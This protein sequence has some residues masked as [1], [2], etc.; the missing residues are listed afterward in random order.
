MSFET[1]SRLVVIPGDP[2]VSYEAAGYGSWLEAYYNPQAMFREVLALSVMEKG[3]RKAHGMTILGVKKQEFGSVLRDLNPTAVRAYGAHWPADLACRHKMPS[4]PVVVSVHDTN[5]NVIHRSVRYADLV[6][7]LSHAVK[8]QIL[9]LGVEPRRIRIL[10]N[11]IDT[12]VF[13][14]IR[15]QKSFEKIATQFPPGKHILHVGRKSEEKNLDTLIRSLRFLPGDYLAVFVGR[16]NPNAYLKLANDV[17]VSA[18]CFWVE[19]VKNSELPLWYSWSDCMCV[20]S[21]WEGFGIVFIEAAA[22]GAAVVTSDIAP[23]NEYLTHNL[24]A[25]MVKD[26]EDPKAV[27]S[28]IRKVCEQPEYRRRLGVEAVAMARQFDQRIVDAAESAIYREL[29][30]QPFLPPPRPLERAMWRLCK[31]P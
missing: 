11:R 31:I 17:G 9:A 28:A 5:P 24:N 10:P 12:N 3:T 26:Y 21:R 18:R 27:A 1:P 23:M 13:R 7:C 22:C 15:N 8:K 19:A 30:S 2:I 14:P 20:L 29:L 6:I 16:G 4:V 25:C